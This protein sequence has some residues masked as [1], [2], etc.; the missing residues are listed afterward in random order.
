MDLGKWRE[1]TLIELAEKDRRIAELEEMLNIRN[2]YRMN[3]ESIKVGDEVC[4]Y[5]DPKLRP[6]FVVTQIGDG[7][8]YGINFKGGIFSN[9]RKSSYRKTGRH[10]DI[11]RLLEELR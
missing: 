9:R 3:G 7:R 11:T 2:K 6:C 5:K 8:L 10:F 1:Q 4:D